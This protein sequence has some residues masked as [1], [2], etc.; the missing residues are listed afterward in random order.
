MMNL[1]VISFVALTAAL[2]GSLAAC[3]DE[4]EETE[5]PCL[6]ETEYTGKM[7]ALIGGLYDCG[8][9]DAQLTVYR[10]C[11]ERCTITL[12]PFSLT[13][14]QMNDVQVGLCEKLVC[15]DIAIKAN[16]KGGYDFEGS[17]R[18]TAMTMFSGTESQRV[19]A[20]T[21]SG[22]FTD[23]AATCTISFPEQGWEGMPMTLCF[24]FEGAI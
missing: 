2:G 18:V 3:S 10:K 5:C 4:E 14:P 8:T 23:E 19:L 6:Y 11:E 22:S 9:V 13:V 7:G 20:G 16:G 12:H 24:T 21:L 15:E 17:F 1:K